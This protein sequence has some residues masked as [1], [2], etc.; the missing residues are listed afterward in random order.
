MSRIRKAWQPYKSE[1]L[2][3]SNKGLEYLNRQMVGRNTR[4]S[5]VNKGGD[6]LC[7][8][9]GQPSR[10]GYDDTGTY[11][12]KR[13]RVQWASRPADSRGAESFLFPCR[14]DGW[15]AVLVPRN[16]KLN[17]TATYGAVFHIVCGC[18]RE[19]NLNANLLTAVRTRNPDFVGVAHS[20][21]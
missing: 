1:A 4:M 18:V 7:H 5:E 21:S 13:D 14:G 10:Y 17:G 19:F 8:P 16:V 12:P 20:T 6:E 3:R 11:D 15:L 9:L 2:S